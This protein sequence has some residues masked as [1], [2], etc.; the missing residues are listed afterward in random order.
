MQCAIS[1]LAVANLGLT[2]AAFGSAT[3]TGLQNTADARPRNVAAA[4]EPTAIDGWAKVPGGVPG[5]V[6]SEVEDE[7]LGKVLG[8]ELGEVPG[9][10]EFSGELFVRPRQNLSPVERTRALA[11]I[12]R[13]PFRA[14]E[15]TDEFIL[16]VGGAP[17]APGV[18]ET[19]VSRALLATDLFEY[20]CPNWILF[21]VDAPNDPRFL[22]QWHHAT[23][24]SADAWDLHR[25]DRVN[26]TIVAFVDTGI[27]QHAELTNRV[28]GFNSVSDVAEADGG[29]LTD[30]HGHGTH[31]AGCAAASGDN[32][33]GVVGMGWNLRIM[34][35]RASEA[36][37]GA[38]SMDNLLQGIRWAAEHGAKVVSASY[39]G[40]GHPPIETTGAYLQTLGANLLWAAGNS[41]VD[42]ASWDFDNVVVVGASDQS[43][44]RASFSSYGRGV[45]LFAPGV[46]I[47]SSTR[48]G[49]YE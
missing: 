18:A 47:L 46:S 25:A 2:A 45:D 8:E 30:I 39:S 14:V 13:H 32:G 10:Y 17:H 16:T 38:A 6:L 4:N 35:I 9:E 28:S 19:Q 26:E 22:E 11:A 7:V 34:P 24:H 5:E 12:A 44:A 41:A 43:D 40:I 23:M 36:A 29:N 3:Q 31:V 1:C 42:H 21:P 48:D 20:A 33:V 49:G 27:A 15:S 37:N